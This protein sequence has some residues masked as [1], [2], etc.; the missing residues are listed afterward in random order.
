MT[1]VPS[2]KR[3]KKGH[4][5]PADNNR[6]HCR[7]KK[8]ITPRLRFGEKVD[9]RAYSTEDPP[10]TY[11][12]NTT[13]ECNGTPTEDWLRRQALASIKRPNPQPEREKTYTHE[14][15]YRDSAKQHVNL[16]TNSPLINRELSATNQ[17]EQN[18]SAPDDRL[19][20]QQNERDNHNSTKTFPSPDDFPTSLNSIKEYVAEKVGE[21]SPLHHSPQEQ[22]E[23]AVLATG[24]R[25]NNNGWTCR[26]RRVHQCHVMVRL[27][28]NQ[29]E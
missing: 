3:T 18:E 17:V 2:V 10:T 24:I 1:R 27:Q 6:L 16:P 21:T 28:R 26:L 25:R 22:K 7:T 9:A 8:L 15:D 11:V 23:N 29:N 4:P 5:R 13:I 14:K 19:L 20:S 12:N